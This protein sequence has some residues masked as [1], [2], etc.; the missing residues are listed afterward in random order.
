MGE[1]MCCSNT[2]SVIT[3]PEALFLRLLEQSDV[4]E[5]HKKGIV[6]IQKVRRDEFESG[7]KRNQY[8]EIVSIFPSAD[9]SSGAIV[10][11]PQDL[12]GDV[13]LCYSCTD[14]CE[15]LENIVFLMN[16]YDNY[17]F[18]LNK[19]RFTKN[20]YV[21]VKD[22]VGA[23]V[24]QD[25]GSSIAFTFNQQN[26]ITTFHSYL[27]DMIYQIPEKERN[28]KTTINKLVEMIANLKDSFD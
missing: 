18:I 19:P 1:Y 13:A 5:N 8:T 6:S 3:M 16:K 10:V 7:L 14:Y 17:H 12:F 25:E 15:H 21:A 23:I 2:L 26:M 28:R 27:E 9:F 11:T 20:I 22:Q 4:N 24:S